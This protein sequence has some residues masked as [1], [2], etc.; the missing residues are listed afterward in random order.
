MSKEWHRL[1]EEWHA[2]F[3]LLGTYAVAFILLLLAATVFTRIS[4]LESRVTELETEV[5]PE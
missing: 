2:R 1:S 3:N 5:C 4:A